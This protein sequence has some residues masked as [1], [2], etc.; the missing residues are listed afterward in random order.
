MTTQ[1]YFDRV[2]E[3]WTGT[4]TGV[5]SLGTAVTGFR[6]FQDVHTS[7]QTTHYF[8]ENPALGEWEV[9][10][11]TL[12][13][14]SPWTLTRTT[15]LASSNS[16]AAVNFSAGSKNICE[17]IPAAVLALIQTAV[18]NSREVTGSGML[19]GGG[20]LTADRT[21]TVA[22]IAAGAVVANTTDSSAVPT[23]VDIDTTFKTAL[24]LASGDISGLGSAA[25]KNVGTGVG[26]VVQLDVSTGKLPAV[27]GSLLTNLPAPST[28]AVETATA[29]ASVGD[30][31]TYAHLKA[32][33]STTISPGTTYAGSGLRYTNDAD[34]VGGGTPSGTWR[35]MGGPGG[36]G[37]TS[38]TVFL[39]IS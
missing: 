17:D 18:Q 16:N 5:V 37:S 15:V 13:S 1:T 36:S 31:G 30:V 28:A 27:D 39:R 14:G 34:T 24:N 32:A 33:S 7:G 8:I 25:T 11:C 21:I 2:Q 10:L 20:D 35:A 38:G 12:A 22:A 19:T 29:G 23:A 4:G 9:G 6:R 3:V 26:N